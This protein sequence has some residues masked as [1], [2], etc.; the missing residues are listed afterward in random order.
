MGISKEDYFKKLEDVWRVLRQ[1][2]LGDINDLESERYLLAYILGAQID[3]VRVKAEVRFPSEDGSRYVKSDYSGHLRDAL[4]RLLTKA[5]IG[6]Q[7]EKKLTEKYANEN[8]K[9]INEKQRLERSLSDS[10]KRISD[11][12]KRIDCLVGKDEYNELV[13][14]YNDLVDEN[15]GLEE[16][17]VALRGE[18]SDLRSKNKK[19]SSLNE[20]LRGEKNLLTDIST[21]RQNALNEITVLYEQE[22]GR[23]DKAVNDLLAER[24]KPVVPVVITKVDNAA[25]VDL[26]KQVSGL[27]GEL[28]EK[29]TIISNMETEISN[30]DNVIAGKNKKVQ[31]QQEHIG[32]LELKVSDL[33]KKLSDTHDDL[34]AQIKGLQQR[35][36]AFETDEKKLVPTLQQVV[37]RRNYQG[38][39]ITLSDKEIDKVI[40]CHLKGMSA[41]QIHSEYGIAE[42]SVKKIVN[43][44]YKS[45][46]A[47]K[48]ILSALHRV[49][50]NWGEERKE[51]LQQLI[52]KYEQIVLEKEAEAQ[53]AKRDIENKIQSIAS[54]NDEVQGHKTAKSV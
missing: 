28:K 30:K 8:R 21:Q 35:I 43:C 2:S 25:I 13:N 52:D 51:A 15:D 7:K 41:Y 3:D 18:V 46:S 54:Y 6:I 1:E 40:R 53:K 16:Q 31:E 33:K 11:L 20:Q 37:Y 44:G 50:G 27:Q 22:K 9:L 19:L 14:E 49:N 47:T 36:E 38:K 48:K 45:L 4:Q 26:Q 34:S 32:Q 29:S 17:I 10:K 12:E 5:N 39:S 24:N 42:S 23:A